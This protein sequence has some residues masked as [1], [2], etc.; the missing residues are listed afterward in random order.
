MK[1]IF[2]SD[3]IS[4]EINDLRGCLMVK[5]RE[6]SDQQLI[7]QI[8]K[9]Q[10][11]LEKLM[12]ERSQRLGTLSGVERQAL[13]LAGEENENSAEEEP[14]QSEGYHFDDEE[15]QQLQN[16]AASGEGAGL[17]MGED[18]EVRVTQLLQLA[19]GDLEDLKANSERIKA[20]G[21][22][23]SKKVVKKKIVKK[24]VVKKK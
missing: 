1:N 14:E 18:E 12:E 10:R 20:Q 2:N 17:G 5:I 22:G 6:L 21:E 8:E 4:L 3:I 9:Y 23:S 24:K 11:T 13:A 16:Q 15:L 19:K 7:Q